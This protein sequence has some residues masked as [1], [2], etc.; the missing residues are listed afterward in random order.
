VCPPGMQVQ[1]FSKNDAMAPDRTG[2]PLLPPRPGRAGIPRELPAAFVRIEPPPAELSPAAA[3]IAE[4]LYALFPAPGDPAVVD[5][6]V[7]LARRQI[8]AGNGQKPT[9]LVFAGSVRSS[10]AGHVPVADPLLAAL[11][12]RPPEFAAGGVFL[13]ARAAQSLEEGYRLVAV[14]D[15]VDDAGKRF[16]LFALGAERTAPVPF[17]NAE[18]LHR[19]LAWVPRPESE[20]LRLTFAEAPVIRLTGPLGAGKSRLAWESLRGSRARVLWSVTGSRRG[21]A[22]GHREQI[23]R[24][25]E[26]LARQLAADAQELIANLVSWAREAPVWIVADGL[27]SATPEDWEWL[28]ALAAAATEEH[29]ALHLLLVGRNGT[30]W[31][32][33]LDGCPRI[34]LGPLVGA[35][36]ERFARQA[37][38]GLSLPAAV[39]ERLR[40]QAAGNP[41]AFEELLVSLARSH[42]LRR[43]VGTFFYSGDEGFEAPPSSRLIGHV[44]AEVARL[45]EADPLRLLAASGEP[46]PDDLLATAAGALGFA[47]GPRWVEPYLASGWLISREG[48]WG[49]GVDFA[50]PV[51]RAALAATLPPESLLMARRALGGRLAAA[52]PERP[53]W[54]T[55]QLLAG[56]LA[57]AR[58]LVA[59]V[60]GPHADAPRAALFEALRSEAVEVA[61]LGEG[62]DLERELLWALLP[63]GRRLGR[64][65]ELGPELERAQQLVA[66]RPERFV[67]IATVHAELEQNAGRYREAEQL[68]RRA[69]AASREGSG[70]DSRRQ[71]LVALELGRV[72]QRQGRR[73]E[74][75]E[76][77]ERLLPVLD[78]GGRHGLAALCRFLLG[79]LALEEHR[80]DDAER[81]HRAALEARRSARGGATAAVASLSALAA[82]RTAM[83]DFF[84]AVALYREADE[85]ARSD[86]GDGEDSF[87][88]LGLGR[89][90]ARIG[91]FA[92]ARGPLRRALALRQGLDDRAGEAIARLAVAENHLQLAQLA[93]AEREARRAHFDLSLLPEGTALGDAELL[94]GRIHLACNRPAEARPH[95]AEAARIHRA[96]GQAVALARDLAA[97]LAAAIAQGETREVRRLALELEDQL[98]TIGSRRASDEP[99]DYHLYRAAVWLRAHGEPE[100]DP[101]PWLERA[102]ATLLE[103][104]SFLAPADRHHFLFG[105][106]LHREIVEAAAREGLATQGG[107]HPVR[108]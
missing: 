54:A 93:D 101:E 95:L 84:Q 48:P 29:G 44:E 46:V 66:D 74:A 52:A 55:Y 49:E 94:L 35:A 88:L 62:E 86:R 31:P 81:L 68:L 53:S 69:L 34:P 56:S 23:A 9:A 85:L 72:L 6:A 70:V 26:V 79:N 89:A 51:W 106:P 63:L 17:R 42:Q 96:R 22:P 99:F 16:P 82:V 3:P 12:R 41:F 37:V 58:E 97:Q 75:R 105:L 39:E 13:T 24:H 73:R 102:Y 19:R 76:L 77:L 71:A 43:V 87:V 20:E 10:S 100:I 47:G 61:A 11:T 98:A 65:G 36:E 5:T 28:L 33:E 80:L 30:P 21:E 59:L 7:R 60:R 18:V 27:E 64:L 92:S 1:Y 83:G 38:A 15:Y 103:Q 25:L 40:R 104:T 4:G 67:A 45:G 32:D 107:T 14:P 91:D 78:A 90:L 2:S 57:G 108:H 8:V 50:A